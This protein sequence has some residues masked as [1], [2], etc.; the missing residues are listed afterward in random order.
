VHEFLKARMSSCDR[1]L[2]DLTRKAAC[3]RLPF[4]APPLRAKSRPREE[5]R[6]ET[7]DIGSLELPGPLQRA[8][9]F[10]QRLTR[11]AIHQVNR[12]P[13]PFIGHESQIAFKRAK[14]HRPANS[15]QDIRIEALN[16]CLKL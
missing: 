3:H 4:P 2:V 8:L 11:Q 15:F 16:S 1:V 9:H 12:H 6:L 13:N 14:P 5:K 10:L 7:L